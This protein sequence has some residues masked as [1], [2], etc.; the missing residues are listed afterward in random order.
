MSQKVKEPLKNILHEGPLAN[1]TKD[2]NRIRSCTISCPSNDGSYVFI[3]WTNDKKVNSSFIMYRDRQQVEAEERTDEQG[4]GEN[5][6]L[7]CTIAHAHAP[8]VVT[9]FPRTRQDVQK[10]K[11]CKVLSLL[12]FH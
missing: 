6:G 9:F 1:T 8:P 12:V 4:G 5:G 2:W 10:K 11:K 3:N 7:R